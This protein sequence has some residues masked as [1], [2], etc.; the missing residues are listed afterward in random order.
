MRE[1]LEREWEKQICEGQVLKD[2]VGYRVVDFKG[3]LV[4]VKT[5]RMEN[6]EKKIG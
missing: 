2:N 6:R 3:V 5:G 4:G 1:R